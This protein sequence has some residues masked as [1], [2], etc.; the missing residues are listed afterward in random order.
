MPKKK[1]K[2][3]SITHV[4]TGIIYGAMAGVPVGATAG[5]LVGAWLGKIAALAA[6]DPAHVT[7]IAFGIIGAVAGGYLAYKEKK[8]GKK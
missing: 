5:T 3:P 7:P 2:P 1:K 8:A 6:L 4:V